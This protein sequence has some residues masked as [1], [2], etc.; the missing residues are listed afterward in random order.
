[1]FFVGLATEEGGIPQAANLLGVTSKTF[2]KLM[3]QGATGISD[4]QYDSLVNSLQKLDVT[5]AGKELIDFGS[6]FQFTGGQFTP[7]ELSIINHA[8]KK[9]PKLK[10]RVRTKFRQMAKQN[11]VLTI[12]E[13]LGDS[14]TSKHKPKGRTR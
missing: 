5:K 7:K 4:Q 13:V 9:N 6:S 8:I 14:P 11:A 10:K 12:K 1:M 2:R 3:R